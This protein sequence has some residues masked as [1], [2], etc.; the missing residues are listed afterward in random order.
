MS[1]LAT[2]QNKDWN[3]F[4]DLKTGVEHVGLYVGLI[5]YTA[6]GAWVKRKA[7]IK[8]KK[9]DSKIRWVRIFP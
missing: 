3:H 6:V 1:M 4:E 7:G 2:V 5:T 8:F 9:R